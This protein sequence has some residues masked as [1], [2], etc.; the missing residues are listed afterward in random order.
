MTI[1][2]DM[3]SPQTTTPDLVALR[4]ELHQ[5]PEIGL[6][7]P[8][9]QAR[10][11]QALEGL[12]LEVTLGKGLSSITAVLR[13]T[14]PG[15]PEQR[16]VL[17][18]EDM[19]ALP[20]VEETGLDW[21]STN[22]NMHACGHDTH[23][24]ML[25]GAAHRLCAVRQQ[26][27]GDVVFMFQ[28]GEEACDG[29]GL[30]IAE[31]V[32]DAP[33]YR[34]GSAFAIHSWA[35]QFAPG[36]F[37]AKPGTIMSAVDTLRVKVV[38]RGGHGSAPHLSLDPVPPMAE[39]I[40]G[41]QVMLSRHFN[42]FDPAVIT[43]GRVRAGEASNVIPDFAEFEATVRSFTP[44]ANDRLHTLVP[45]LLQGIATSHGV[46]VEVDFPHIYPATINTADEVA[47]VRDAVHEVFGEQRWV[48]MPNS[49]TA[50]EDFSRVLAEVP[51]CYLLLSGV[52]EGVDPA[53][54]AN[55]HSPRAHYD[56][57]WLDDGAT[58]LAEV[59]LRQLRP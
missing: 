9:T 20:V 47:V 43:V 12:P 5:I 39:M 32:L 50:S 49:M 6:D 17:L 34:V 27:A 33:G 22:G 18:R 8:K 35:S 19:D 25:V 42:V 53:G 40:T 31:G 55:N 54:Q 11:L 57:A 48:E 26:L 16:A 1:V 45:E 15:R 3:T 56:D 59:A 13:G 51:G 46:S 4:H 58:L 24:A 21:A 14:A 7:L 28:P 38:G 2:D 30:M 41:L 23:M 36:A 44:E 52:P 29:A 10:I 37:A